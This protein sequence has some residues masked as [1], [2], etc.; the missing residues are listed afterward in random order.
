MTVADYRPFVERMIQR[1]EGGYGW[2]KNDPGGPTKYGITCFD[3]AEH[4]HQ[5]MDS[6]IRWAP[7]VQAM[8]FVEADDIYTVKY[9]TACR[10]SDLNAGCD[11][12][13]FDFEVNSGSSRSIK[14]AQQ[15]VGVNADGI[16]GPVTLQAI[17]A[18]SADKFVNALCDARLTFLR[19]LLNWSHFGG[20][21]NARVKD[22]RVYSLKLAQPGRQGAPLGPVEKLARIPNAYAKSYSDAP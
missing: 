16:L 15:I 3:L 17:N 21:W 10:F 9:A 2:N 12:V 19:S 8:G 11:C 18:Y 6:M 13:V 7:I 1:Y 22:L 5:V 4:R 14:Y 20:G